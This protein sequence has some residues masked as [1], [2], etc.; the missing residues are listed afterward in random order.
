MRGFAGGAEGEL[1]WLLSSLALRSPSRK[2]RW[3]RLLRP[4]VKFRWA[5]VLQGELL[6]A[7]LKVFRGCLVRV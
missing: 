3:A 7:V 4:G 2:A 6:V 1:G 5:R